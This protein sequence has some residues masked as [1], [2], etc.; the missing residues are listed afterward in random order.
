MSP[1]TTAQPSIRLPALRSD[2]IGRDEEVAR[3][4]DWLAMPDRRLVTLI[5]P[6]GV[7]KTT[8]AIAVARRFGEQHSRDV[9]FAALDAIPS[10]DR[11]PV[12]LIDAL[13][14]P[15][16]GQ[17]E[18]RTRLLE[19]LRET[20]LL[21]VLDNF[22]HL[23]E[24]AALVAEVLDG[25]PEVK[26]LVTSR[27]ALGL[28]GEWRFA[29]TGLP[30]PD[31]DE[32]REAAAYPAVQLFARRAE[33]ARSDFSLTREE[34]HVVRICR[35]LEGVPL[36]LELAASWAATLSCA[37]IAAEIERSIDFL[38]SGLRDVPSRHRSMRAVFEQSWSRL[39]DEEQRVFARLSAFHGGFDRAAAGQVAGASLSVLASLVDKSL[40]RADADACYRLH[41]V[42]RQCAE[43][44]LADS[45]DDRLRTLATHCEYYLG[46]VEEQAP[47]L[48]GGRQ[49]EAAQAIA[50][51]FDNV[52]AAWRWAL[53]HDDVGKVL[54]TAAPLAS[55]HQFRGRYAEGL[56]LSSHAVAR[57]QDGEA[58]PD[59]LAALAVL[60]V[61]RGW[62]NIRLGRIAEAK[63][64]LEESRRIWSEHAVPP[65]AGFATEPLTPLAIVAMIEGD[66][67]G[68]ERL[69]QEALRADEAAGNDWNTELALYALTSAHSAR[70]RYEQA[71]EYGL[72]AYDM[73]RAN[74]DRWHMAYSLNELGDIAGALGEHDAAREC[75]GASYEIRR[76]FD[77]PEG[78]AVAL[79]RLG[80]LART[81]GDQ[82]EAA[83][84]HR[85]ALAIYRRISDQGGLAVS[86]RGL[87][88]TSRAGG[89]PRQAARYFREAMEIARGIGHVPLTLS[90]LA[91]AGALLLDEGRL[92]A[93]GELLGCV[94]EHA[95]A[96]QVTAARAREALAASG[97]GRTSDRNGPPTL[98]AVAASAHAELVTLEKHAEATSL[99]EL[100]VEPLTDR[101]REILERIAGGRSNQE[102]A[103]EL[104]VSIGTVKAHTG[105][106]YSKL[107]VHNRV[108][109][110]A[111]ARELGL[112]PAS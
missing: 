17:A 77:D 64:A 34:E 45:P 104:I 54:R 31:G 109:A 89:A 5:G 20:E 35:L 46:Y 26:L 99:D 88:E 38:E 2:I 98:D 60:L 21:L 24:S 81:R 94:S 9:A 39:T 29:V 111:R 33:Q 42:L 86:L 87:G 66:Y 44:R 72:R 84:C 11:L 12:A 91:G 102:I 110:L 70:G 69:G 82:Q 95:S 80:D 13:G 27:E 107:G 97:A 68:A 23:L 71:R 75:Y 106:I 6:G 85:R 4:V 53:E 37:D 96:D 79:N 57:L 43:E 62:F 93:A 36:A 52:L 67:D 18:P 112:L 101:E 14:I 56:A 48:A 59:R 58:T 10:P 63:E 8:L 49:V 40:V 32:R 15:Q 108:Q 73:A 28:R 83:D 100:Y 105:N 1:R 103:S 19:S 92:Q 47:G 3:L 55:F 74:G 65:V 30:V 7:G 61:E 51:E 16:R 41:E 76:E 50:R 25:A 90:V 22:E 78:M